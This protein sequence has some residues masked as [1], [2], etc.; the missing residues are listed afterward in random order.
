MSCSEVLSFVS[1]NS[2]EFSERHHESL[3]DDTPSMTTS[4]FNRSSSV[5]LSLDNSSPS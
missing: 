2:L 5:A 1:E 3:R 4:K